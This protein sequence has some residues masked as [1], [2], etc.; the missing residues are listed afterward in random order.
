MRI[1]LALVEDT[2]SEYNLNYTTCGD[3][4]AIKV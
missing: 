4:C 2:S 3:M 1:Y